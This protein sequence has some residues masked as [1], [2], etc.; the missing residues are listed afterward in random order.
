LSGIIAEIFALRP[1]KKLEKN[2][3]M[4]NFSRKL[5]EDIIKVVKRRT[6]SWVGDVA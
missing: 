1:Y 6:I 2:G 5:S 4:C 3:K